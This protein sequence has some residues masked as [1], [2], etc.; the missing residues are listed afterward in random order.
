MNEELKKVCNKYFG[1]EKILRGAHHGIIDNS[2]Y[3]LYQVKVDKV[4]LYNGSFEWLAPI[5]ATDN[6]E[7]LET[8]IKIILFGEIK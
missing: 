1:A 3:L 7:V 5:I 4:I 8:L 6:P 2:A